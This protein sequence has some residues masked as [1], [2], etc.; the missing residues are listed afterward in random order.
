VDRADQVYAILHAT[1]SAILP[2]EGL[3]DGTVTLY[4]GPQHAQTQREIEV[5]VNVYPDD[6]ESVVFHAMLLGPKFHRY[7]EDYPND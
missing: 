2:D 1:Y 4:I 6:R 5:L 3:D 7:R